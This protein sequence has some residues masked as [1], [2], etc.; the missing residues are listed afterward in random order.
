MNHESVPTPSQHEKKIVHKI[1]QIYREHLDNPSL[2][3]AHIEK[4]FQRFEKGGNILSHKQAV[5]I[6][7]LECIAEE[8]GGILPEG[9]LRDRYRE[10][11]C[12]SIIKEMQEKNPF[13]DTIDYWQYPRESLLQH[14][15]F[16][17]MWGDEL[18]AIAESILDDERLGRTLEE[19][20]DPWK[21]VE[22][23][24]RE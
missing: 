14:G 24:Y 9:A 16:V 18:H 19:K 8:E 10:L 2:I 3:D 23:E 6:D 1:T 7:A 20:N 13:D 15:P 17:H 12:E 5:H 11:V 21:H 22:E 4:A